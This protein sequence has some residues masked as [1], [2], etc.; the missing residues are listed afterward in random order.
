MNSILSEF[1]YTGFTKNQDEPYVSTVGPSKY[2]CVGIIDIV[3]ST[4]TVAKLPQN[5]AP[6]YYELFLNLMAKTV[7]Q[8]NAKILKTMGDG[9]LFYFPDTCYSD[10]KFCFLS[11]IEYGFSL[12]NSHSNLNQ[13]LE[14]E[15]IP[16][17]DFRI[18]FDYGLVTM[19]KN[20]E[21]KFDLVGPTINTCAKINSCS[22]IN[23]MVF[24]GGGSL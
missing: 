14:D 21:W 22:P 15:G 8:F 12:M 2:F 19:M 23:G 17:I 18:S 7:M 6:R 4:N 9:L 13:Q 16:Q 11:A 1:N 3:N 24:G 20:V 10:R 5:K